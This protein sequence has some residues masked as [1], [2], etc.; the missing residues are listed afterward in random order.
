MNRYAKGYRLEMKSKKW[1]QEDGYVVPMTSRGSHGLFDLLAI[2]QRDDPAVINKAGIQ[3]VQ[4]KAN[5]MP[6]PGEMALLRDFWVPI[7]IV[8][9]VHI[10]RDGAKAPEV[11]IV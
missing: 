4:V 6:P 7:G 11:H 1:L 5:R 9:V 3:L 8:K 2:R 10:W